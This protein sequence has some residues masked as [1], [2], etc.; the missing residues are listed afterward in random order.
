[1]AEISIEDGESAETTVVPR[2]AGHRLKKED[3]HVSF[4]SPVKETA[5]KKGRK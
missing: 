4:V 5:P 2:G 1:V 3:K